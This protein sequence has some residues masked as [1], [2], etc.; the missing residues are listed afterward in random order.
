M[1]EGGEGR[2]GDLEGDVDGGA[3][4]GEVNEGLVGVGVEGVEGEEGLVEGVGEPEG[5]LVGD[6]PDDEGAVLDAAASEGRPH[7]PHEE[8]SV[9]VHGHEGELHRPRGDGGVEGEAALEDAGRDALEAGQRSA[10]LPLLTARRPDQLNR[11]PTFAYA[12]QLENAGNLGGAVEGDG[13][14]GVGP[15][16][17]DGAGRD[18]GGGEEGPAV[19]GEEMGGDGGG[20]GAFPEEAHLLRVA[21]EGRDVGVDPAEGELLVEEAGVARDGAA[22][23]QVEVAERPEAVVDVDDDHVLLSREDAAIVKGEGG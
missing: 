15:A 22:A 12:C 18:D 17:G 6:R 10:Q 19:G 4:L 20:A 1:K 7:R 9:V 14:G 16:V 13:V 21:T 8:R 23:A 3:E 11:T 2:E 5:A